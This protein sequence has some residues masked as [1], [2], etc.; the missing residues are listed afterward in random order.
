[1]VAPGDLYGERDARH[2]RIALVQPIERLQLALDRL[3]PVLAG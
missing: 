3:A 2:V 1:L